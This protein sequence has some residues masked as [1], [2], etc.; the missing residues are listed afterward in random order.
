MPY[1]M[2][3]QELELLDDYDDDDDDDDDGNMDQ[4]MDGLNF[5][6]AHKEAEMESSFSLAM[7]DLSMLDT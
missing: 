2:S 7:Q 5:Q 4:L 3:Q 1:I 6:D